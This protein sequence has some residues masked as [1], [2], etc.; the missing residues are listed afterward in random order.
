MGFEYLPTETQSV[1]FLLELSVSYLTC[2]DDTHVQLHAYTKR[3]IQLNLGN[4][5][6]FALVNY[7]HGLGMNR[8]YISPDKLI[9]NTTTT[10]GPS[11]LVWATQ[12]CRVKN[13][14]IFRLVTFQGSPV[15]PFENLSKDYYIPRSIHIHTVCTIQYT[16]TA[17]HKKHL[18]T[19][20]R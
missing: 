13:C 19:L 18:I 4:M 3:L 11:R 9:S 17:L 6:T 7:D 20:S 8:C 15:F 14:H 5:V 12:T 10:I 1:Y 16:P 2:P